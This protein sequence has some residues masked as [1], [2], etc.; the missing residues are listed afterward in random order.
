[1][2]KRLSRTCAEIGRAL[3]P[4]NCTRAGKLIPLHVAG[5][6]PARRAQRL[7]HHLGACARCRAEAEEYAASRAWLQAGAQPVF[8]DE[9]YDGIR[10]A[11]LSQIRR[12]QRRA[13]FFAPANNRRLVYAAASLA[14]L[15][16]VGALVWQAQFGHTKRTVVAM[17]DNNELRGPTATPTATPGRVE[18]P[19]RP[20]VAGTQRQRRRGSVPVRSTRASHEEV[21][22]KPQ[23]ERT[24]V[25]LPPMDN[26]QNDAA[27]VPS[28][29][30]VARIEIQTADPN[31]RIIWLAPQ[32]AAEQPKQEE[33]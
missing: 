29:T 13:P 32:P 27:N 31:I 14:L 17:K 26:A 19:D 10:T 23:P 12:E 25:L 11:V 28:T 8:E 24:P 5:D 6:L 22:Q 1:M 16:L 7:A 3:K 18:Q 33:K 30:E 2:L 9:F 21:A 4:M 20:H 15:C